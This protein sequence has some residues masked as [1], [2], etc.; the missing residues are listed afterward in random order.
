MKD[1]T[2]VALSGLFFLVFVIGIGALTLNKPLSNILSAK[3][4]APSPLKSFGVV[5]P[6]TA[7]LGSPAK[8]SIY[9]RGVDGSIL[10][11]KT[12]K[13]SGVPAI[14]IAPSDTSVT[15]EIGQAQFSVTVQ[16]AGKVILK[17]VETSSNT[18]V[19]NIPSIEFVQ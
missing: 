10:A 5:F 19:I 9:I 15:N 16:T 14:T 17:A 13:L 7:N 8:V 4:V 1:K 11:N 3:N 18:E 6:Q 12:V 2:F